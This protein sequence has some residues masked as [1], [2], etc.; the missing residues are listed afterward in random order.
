[1]DL[2]IAGPD[3]VG[4][5]ARL[6]AQAQGLGVGDRIHWLG[7]LAGDVKWGAFR[8]CNGFVL[9]SHTENFGI[10]VAEA[11][12]TG[13]AVLITNKV[14]VW[15]EVES[16]GGG[17]AVDDDAES[18]Y[19]MLRQFLNLSMEEVNEMGMRAR[20]CYLKHFTIEEFVRR[21]LDFFAEISR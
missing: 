5:R 18:I 14:K 8:T 6:E 16:S 11:M 1:V 4:L 10:V 3:E 17:L 15:K 21:Q 20:A 7:M 9:P 12:A 2:V 19:S 13:T